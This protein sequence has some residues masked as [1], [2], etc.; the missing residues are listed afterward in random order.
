MSERT[1]KLHDILALCVLRYGLTQDNRFA[2]AALVACQ[3]L[4]AGA[5]P[6][7]IGDVQA[8][9]TAIQDRVVASIPPHS[10]ADESYATLAAFVRSMGLAEALKGEAAFRFGKERARTSLRRL[11]P[12]LAQAVDHGDLRLAYN[13]LRPE[14]VLGAVA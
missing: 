5:R 3:S 9:L 14:H 7:A 10:R 11:A 12:E 4:G 8:K 1:G 6:R 2:L 13:F